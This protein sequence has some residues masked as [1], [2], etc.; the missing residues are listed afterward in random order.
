MK[1]FLIIVIIFFGLNGFS[2]KTIPEVLKKFN[3]NSVSYIS[4]EELKSKRNVIILDAREKNEFETS[5]LKNANFIGYNNFNSK[6]IIQ[7]YKNQDATIVVYCSIGIRSEK[8][9]EKL[10]KL[11][12]KNVYNLYGGIFEWK[13]QNQEVVDSEQKPTENVHAFSKEW[14]EYLLKGNKIITK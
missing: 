8:I 14:S 6:K 9:G 4:V 2:Q 3:K 7:D 1:T 10:L 13:N 5:H 12:Y 11:G